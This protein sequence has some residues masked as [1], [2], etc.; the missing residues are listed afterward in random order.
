MLLNIVV[1]S[2]VFLTSV[3]LSLFNLELRLCVQTLAVS[4]R[5]ENSFTY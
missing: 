1:D 4:T 2:R 5:L 3:H